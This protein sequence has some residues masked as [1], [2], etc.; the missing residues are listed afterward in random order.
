LPYFAKANPREGLAIKSL[1]A[2]RFRG[3]LRMWK[4]VAPHTGAW[5]ETSKE[6]V[7]EQFQKAG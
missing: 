7:K 1:R 2:F 4:R 5:I 3:K 6:E